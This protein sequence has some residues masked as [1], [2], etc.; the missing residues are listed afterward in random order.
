LILE[1]P[2]QC[3]TFCFSF[4]L[5][6]RFLFLTYCSKLNCP[7]RTTVKSWSSVCWLIAKNCTIF[8]RLLYICIWFRSTSVGINHHLSVDLTTVT[9]LFTTIM[10]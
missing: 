1:L 6:I 5:K 4:Y 3:G 9:R 7:S 8:L 10:I 2:R